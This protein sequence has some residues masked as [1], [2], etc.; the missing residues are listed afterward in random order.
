M[1]MKYNSLFPFRFGFLLLGII[2]FLSFD[3]FAQ[4]TDQ[5]KAP[6]IVFPKGEQEVPSI[7]DPN[8][9]NPFFLGISAAPE[10]E[11]NEREKESPSMSME[12]KER[13]LDPGERYLKK[14]RRNTTPENQKKAY[15]NTQKLYRKIKKSQ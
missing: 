13:F 12:Q 14:L 4:T 9:Q 5:Q 10:L 1:K 7:I 11:L 15:Y 8:N 3:G 2:L 6:S